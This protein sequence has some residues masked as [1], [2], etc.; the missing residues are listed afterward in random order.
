LSFYAFKKYENFEA[1][2]KEDRRSFGRFFSQTYFDYVENYINENEKKLTD[3][4]YS[5][6]QLKE[7]IE[8]LIDKKFVWEKTY[9]LITNSALDENKF[10]NNNSN[11]HIELENNVQNLSRRN[12]NQN[13]LNNEGIYHKIS[14]N[15]NNY[16]FNNNIIDIESNLNKDR[17]FDLK[18][19]SGIILAEEELKFKKLIFRTT[20]G[21][22]YP[23]IFELAYAENQMYSV[24]GR[25][26]NSKNSKKNLGNFA[27]AKN[28]KIFVLCVQ[29]QGLLMQKILK[30]CDIIRVARYNIPNI[31]EFYAEIQKLQKEIEGKKIF[32]VETENSIKNFVVESE[33]V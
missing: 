14:I 4:V 32:L 5:Y 8:E 1:V 24:N 3:L 22:A 21:L 17:V 31:N 10:N 29:G 30:I 15:I 19:I 11:I 9:Q 2:F 25:N 26:L 6:N 23:N 28:K 20:K 12:N 18:I 33:D 7:N 27:E 13:N 16:N